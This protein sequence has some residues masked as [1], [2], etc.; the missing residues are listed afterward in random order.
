MEF[1]PP[2]GEGDDLE[3][4]ATNPLDAEVE[5][6]DDEGRDNSGGPDV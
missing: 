6:P 4:K 2:F 1:M 3:G 5:A